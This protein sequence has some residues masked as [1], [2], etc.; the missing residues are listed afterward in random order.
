VTESND[1]QLTIRL[2]SEI[3]IAYLGQRD[4]EPEQVPHFIRMVRA[5]LDEGAPDLSVGEELA[6]AGSSAASDSPQVPAVRPED[7][8]TPDYLISLEDGKPYR[9]LRRHLMARYGL[10]PEAYRKKWNLPPDYPM[11][12]PNYSRDRS[13]VAKRIGL[14]KAPSAKVSQRG[15][16]G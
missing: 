1:P 16:S 9:S 13:K 4:L 15:S 5:A 14:G 12:A 7:S 8:I 6:E 2:A 10:T 3:V 11:V